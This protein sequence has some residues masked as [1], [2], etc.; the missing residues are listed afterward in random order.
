[1]LTPEKPVHRC[2]TG[3]GNIPGPAAPAFF[4]DCSIIADGSLLNIHLLNVQ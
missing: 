1:M 3:I 4:E 2:I